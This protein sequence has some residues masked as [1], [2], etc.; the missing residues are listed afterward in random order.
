MMI[1]AFRL[2]ALLAFACS[3]IAITPA[4]AADAAALEGALDVLTAHVNKSKT[5]TTEEIASELETLNTNAAAIGEDAASIENVIEFINAYD[6]RHK[7]LFIGK[8]Q[9]HQKK[10]DSSDTIHWA[11]FW[12][13]Q[14][15]F[16][17]VYHSKGLKKYGDLIGSLKFRTADY[18]PGKVEAPINPEAYTVTINGSYPDVWGS[19]QFQDERPAVKPT[20]AYLVPGTTA[21]IIVPESLV[22]RGYQVRVGAH[23][24]DLE[25]KPRVERLFR[26]S[27][28]YDIDSTEVR[29]ANPLGGGIYIEVPP[30]ADAGI[31]EVAVKNAARSP[32]FSWKHFHRTSLKEWRESERHHKAPWTDFQSDKFMVQVPT[33]WIYKM[34]DP[35]TYMNEWDLSM[36]RMNDLM[37]RPHLFGRETVYTQVDT[38]LRGRAFH[39]GYPGVNAGYD[40]RKDY[41]GYHNHHLVRGPRN[42]HSYEFHEKGH[43]FL[44]PKY[45]GDREAAVNLPHVAVMSQAFGMDLDAAFRSSRGEKNDFRTLDTTAIA[46]MMSQNFVEDGFMKP[47]ERQYQLKGHAKYVDVARLF[48]WHMLG[49]FWESTHADYEAGNSWPKDVRDDDSDRYTVRLSKVTGAD[50]RPLLHFWGIPP[51][52]FEKQAKAIHDLG[53]Q[54]SQAVYD[55]LAHYKSLIPE[56]RG[57]FRKYAKSWWEKQP[58]EDGYTT[59]RNHAAYWESYDKAVAEKVRGTLQKIMDTYFPDGRPES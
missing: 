51:H 48:G 3:A 36:D 14:H 49:R 2:Y 34:D 19:P 23:S 45:A 20:G 16:D 25:K 31:V 59:E 18:F 8:K 57:A 35:A 15:L 58:N 27:A 13:M 46:W 12:A 24:W 32:Y 9:L 53:I 43:G 28:L 1:P 55:T 50:L 54:P 44:F 21:T 40:P 52:D 41:G 17:Q 38:Q 22:G 30:G 39:P 56:D 47:Y 4:N 6:A 33:S 11:A 42:A 10:K 7:P 37:G 5:L 26:V 29:V